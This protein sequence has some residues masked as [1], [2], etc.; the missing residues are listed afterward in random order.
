MKNANNEINDTPNWEFYRVSQGLLTHRNRILLVGNDYGY[1]DLIWSLPGGR[2]EKGEQHLGGLKRE[3]ME[4]T[5]LDIVPENLL[6][7]V[8]ARSSIHLKQFVTLVFKVKLTNP[9]PESMDP[10]LMCEVNG[11]VKE[12]RFVPFE[13]VPGYIQ[14]PSLGEG[15]VNYLFYGQNAQKYWHYPE[16]FSENWIPLQWPPVP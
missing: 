5:G 10:A 4:E 13:E 14:R 11:P 6:Y 8:D 7:V 1:A 3:F 16:Y 9:V 2:L 12:V 15:L